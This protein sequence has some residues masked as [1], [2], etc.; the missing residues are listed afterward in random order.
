MVLVV[1]R[2]F[3]DDWLDH[4]PPVDNQYD[5]YMHFLITDCNGQVAKDGCDG[6]SFLLGM[7]C[8]ESDPALRQPST[9][10]GLKWP[11]FSN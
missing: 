4:K 6:L 7:A 8:V 10:D 11:L 3:W 1:N 9:V 5:L 2:R